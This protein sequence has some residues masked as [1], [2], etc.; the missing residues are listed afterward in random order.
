MQE[1]QQIH[2]LV[3]QELHECW[4]MVFKNLSL[5]VLIGSVVT[6]STQSAFTFSNF[7]NL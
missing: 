2:F 5:T 7:D 6:L 1:I 3:V 4:V